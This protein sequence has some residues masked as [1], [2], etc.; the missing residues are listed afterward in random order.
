MSLKPVKKMGSS[1]SHKL[2]TEK[3]NKIMKHRKLR[4]IAN[5]LR[6]VEMCVVLV[7][8]SRASF[9]HLPVALKISSEYF[10]GFMVSPR[11]VFLIG[12]VIIIALFAQ[13]GQFSGKTTPEP[14]FYLEFLQNSTVNQ[15]TQD[16]QKR[17]SMKSENGVKDHHH[18]IDGGMIKTKHPEKQSTDGSMI[19]LPEK[20]STRATTTGLEIVE[21][22]DYRRCQSEITRRMQS[23]EKDRRVLQRCETENRMRRSN[24]GETERVGRSSYPEDGMS[25]DDFRRTVEAFIGRQQRLREHELQAFSS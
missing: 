21:V 19:K 7:L 14:D 13:S 16:D 12:N 4:K 2:K 1:N 5:L 25:N 8:I 15:E 10:S 17:V 24:E 22:K 18:R 11:F 20:Q 9:Q 3:S 23:D 6:Y